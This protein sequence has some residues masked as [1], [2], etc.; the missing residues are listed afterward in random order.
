MDERSNAHKTSTKQSHVYGHPYWSI[1]ATWASSAVRVQYKK[2][3]SWS[4]KDGATAKEKDQ[5]K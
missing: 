1:L 5:K 3:Y 2:N 4:S